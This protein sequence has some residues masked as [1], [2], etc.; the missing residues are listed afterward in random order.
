MADSDP[1][2]KI[3]YSKLGKTETGRAW[4][5]KAI[6]PPGTAIG[7]I[8]GM[9]DNEAFPSTV[10]EFRNTYT[11]EPPA[12]ATTTWNLLAC[13]M[14]SAEVPLLG[15]SWAS[16]GVAPTPGNAPVLSG[17]P[18]Y[19]FDNWDGDVARWRRLYGSVTA[20]LNA[21]ALNDQGMVY[22]AQQRLEVLNP[23]TAAGGGNM[24]VPSQVVVVPSLPTAPSELQQISPGFYKH[25]AKEGCFAVSGLCQPT[26]LYAPGTSKR[27]FMGTEAQLALNPQVLP[28]LGGRT[29]AWA[30]G[31]YGSVQTGLSDNWSSSWMLFLGISVNATVEFKVI[32]AYECQAALG[33]SFGLF[34]EPS[35]A[36]DT[37][38]VD[39]YY[40]LRHGMMDGYPAAY[41]FF[42]SLMA[43]LSSL[44]PKIA[45]WLLPAAKQAVP[46]IAGAVASRVAPAA[47]PRPAP[48]PQARAPPVAAP[49]PSRGGGEVTKLRELESR[50]ANLEVGG[51]IRAPKP[52]H[53]AQR[54]SR[55]RRRPRRRGGARQSGGPCCNCQHG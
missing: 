6:H 46:A 32:H 41:N 52:L 25:R 7:P 44:V 55:P 43:G 21:P 26:N 40:A 14:P 19:N 5:E 16:G 13:A 31:D 42:G 20:E 37:A 2:T 29:M 12:G 9:P 3:D 4:L 30:G 27:C 15:W 23:N 54:R 47:A 39:A 11:A 45:S 8:Q 10:M 33:S 38:A 51:N 18:N 53:Q 48:V 50:L 34:V 24:D 49:R 28:D 22:C 35:A 17:N 36:P 1:F